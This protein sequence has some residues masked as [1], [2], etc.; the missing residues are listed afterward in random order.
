MQSLQYK[1]TKDHLNL[2]YNNENQWIYIGSIKGVNARITENNAAVGANGNSI[3]FEFTFPEKQ[4]NF[5]IPCQ[6]NMEAVKIIKY[7]EQL[8]NELIEYTQVM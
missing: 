1:I 8:I 4:V 5:N 7:G 6:N 3:N 2:S